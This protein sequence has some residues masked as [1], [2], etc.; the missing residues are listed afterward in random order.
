MGSKVTSCF[1]LQHLG[2][3][4]RSSWLYWQRG[5]R[6]RHIEQLA[7]TD[8][9]SLTDL[10]SWMLLQLHGSYLR[11]KLISFRYCCCRLL[12]RAF[13]GFLIRIKTLMIDEF[14]HDSF[15]STKLSHTIENRRTNRTSNG[16][17]FGLLV[18][19]HRHSHR[20][21]RRNSSGVSSSTPSRH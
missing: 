10:R 13:N 18:V 20:G 2:K 11:T 15:A 5:K 12:L 21:N 8:R 16:S 17:C 6:Y 9:S 7:L 14:L 19:W 1:L 3:G 4:R